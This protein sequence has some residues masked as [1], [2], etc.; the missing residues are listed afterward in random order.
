MRVLTFTNLYPSAAQP[1]HG[2]FVEHRIRQL[3]ASGRVSS[4]VVAPVPWMPLA[5]FWSTRHAE[6]ARVAR[7]ET[8]HGIAVQRARFLTIPGVTSWI[9]PLSMALSA[10]PTN[11]IAIPKPVAA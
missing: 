8:R 2:I 11:P 3:T 9:N 1:R 6:L 10:L 7:N 4:R 5:R